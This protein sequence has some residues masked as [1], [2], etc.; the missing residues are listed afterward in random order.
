[1]NATAAKPSVGTTVLRQLEAIA[2][3]H[4]APRV[5]RLNLPNRPATAG[6]NDAE[7]C[8]IEL[9][10]GAFGLSYVLLGDTLT[11]LVRAHSGGT[12]A[13]ADPLALAQHL[14]GG[15]ELE[16]AIALTTINALTDSVWRHL[17]YEPLPAGN[18]LGDV[19]LGP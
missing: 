6:E 12:L 9:E 17:G 16:R 10:D 2:Q 18:S 1:M 7:F 4:P 3:R 15:N 5:K 8:A 19:T 14:V 11:S 13:G